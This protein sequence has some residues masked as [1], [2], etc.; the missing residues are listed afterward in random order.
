MK[1]ASRLVLK[2]FSLQQLSIWGDRPLQ[3]ITPFLWLDNN[4]EEAVQFHTSIFKNSKTTGVT[5]YG[6]ANEINQDLTRKRG[7]DLRERS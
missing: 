3:K 7:Q 2:N 4:A 6:V 1:R 5:H